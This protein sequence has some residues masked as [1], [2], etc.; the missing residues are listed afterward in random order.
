MKLLVF[1]HIGG[2][3]WNKTKIVCYVNKLKLKSKQTNGQTQINKQNK[4]KRKEKEN[5]D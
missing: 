1:V 5:I 2:S 4:E 3:R